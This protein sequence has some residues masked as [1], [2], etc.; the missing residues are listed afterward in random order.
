M[1]KL[2]AKHCIEHLLYEISDKTLHNVAARLAQMSKQPVTLF[3]N[4]EGNWTWPVVKQLLQERGYKCTQATQGPAWI[5][6]SPKYLRQSPGFV[7]FIDKNN[8]DSWKWNVST[9]TTPQAEMNIKQ[10]YARL[11]EGDTVVVHKMWAPLEPFFRK[12]KPFHITTDDSEWTRY[13]CHPTSCWRPEP[14]SYENRECVVKEFMKAHKK[15]KILIS[16]SQE[17]ILAR[18][19]KEGWKTEPILNYECMMPEDIAK[20]VAEKLADKVV[21]HIEKKGSGWSIMAHALFSTCHK[22]GETLS[23]QDFSNLTSEEQ[24]ILEKYATGMYKKTNR[25]NN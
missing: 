10:V 3:A 16:N 7:G 14:V 19:T 18:P 21:N 22:L 25:K 15:S 11:Q 4:S 9:W 5:R 2:K 1:D 20:Q 24:N 23:I 13:E 8:L 12:E 6:D 17:M